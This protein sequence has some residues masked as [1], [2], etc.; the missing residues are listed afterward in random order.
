[1]V[2]F[3]PSTDMARKSGVLVIYPWMLATDKSKG[4][5]LAG[6][7]L[8]VY[9]KLY[10]YT[11]DG[12]SV[13]AG[14]ASLLAENLCV[15]RRNVDRALKHLQA[16]GLIEYIED[17]KVVDKGSCSTLSFRCVVRR[18]AQAEPAPAPVPSLD[19]LPSLGDFAPQPQAEPAPAKPQRQAFRRPSAEEVGAYAAERGDSWLDPQEFLD[20]YDRVGWRYKGQPIKDWKACVRTWES[21]RKKKA[22]EQPQG[23]RRMALP[24]MQAGPQQ[25]ARINW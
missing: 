6:I 24:D 19:D 20:Y 2:D 25:P 12:V 4:L 18:S 22:A 3:L 8:L 23:A 7:E 17:G 21:F 1:M 9:A 15:S 13:F 5:G 14:G 16:T 11:Q 10:G